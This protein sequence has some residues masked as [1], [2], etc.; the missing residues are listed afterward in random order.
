MFVSMATRAFDL[1][2]KEL[3][4]VMPGVPRVPFSDWVECALDF[5][6][7]G[8]EE[9]LRELSLG[10]GRSLGEGNL[11]SFAISSNHLRQDSGLIAQ[12]W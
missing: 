9:A 4:G 10:G 12:I 8:G 3:D 2:R 1:R 6:P 5:R 7:G 11:V